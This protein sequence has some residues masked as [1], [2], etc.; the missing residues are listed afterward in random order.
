VVD[1]QVLEEVL[2]EHPFDIGEIET[3][4]DVGDHVYPGQGLDIDV[5]PAVEAYTAA[6]DVQAAPGGS[7]RVRHHG[8][9]ESITCPFGHRACFQSLPC[10]ALR[11][12]R[13][14][15]SA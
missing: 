8:P 4:G 11:Q 14:T 3:A 10:R 9:D 1:R 7:L 5:Q 15:F 12:N 2:S 13:L 6:P